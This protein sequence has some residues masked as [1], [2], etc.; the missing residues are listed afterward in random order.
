MKESIYLTKT[1]L[2]E[3]GVDGKKIS[4]NNI[5]SHSEVDM[6][7]EQ[8]S[9]YIHKRTANNFSLTNIKKQQISI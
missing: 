2:W 6:G 7:M 3:H 4:K 8:A 9:C 5:R 1:Q